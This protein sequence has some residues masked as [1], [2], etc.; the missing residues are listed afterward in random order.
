[1]K[2]TDGYWHIRAGYNVLYPI[3]I[4]DHEIDGGS[5]TVYASTK[6]INHP[7]DTLNTALITAKFSSPMEDVICVEYSHFQG[8]DPAGPEYELPRARCGKRQR[9]GRTGGD[10]ADEREA[11]RLHPEAGRL[12]RGLFL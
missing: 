3:E 10:H 1:M 12:E 4:R 2:F 5:V 11:V 6:K 8:A 9:R 7:G